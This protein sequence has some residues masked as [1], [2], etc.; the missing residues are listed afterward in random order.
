MQQYRLNY[1]LL[2]SLGVGFV[3][4]SAAVYVLHKYQLNRNAKALLDQ[5]VT[6]E[7]AGKHQDAADAYSNYLSIRPEDDAVRVKYANASGDVT[8]EDDVTP[9]DFGRGLMVM[10]ETVRNLPDEKALQKRLVDMYIKVQRYQDAI[11]HL[12]Y[13]LAKYPDEA[14][15]QVLRTESLVH[16]GGNAEALS[17]ALKLIGYD[18]KSD[19]FDV[20]KAIAPNNASSYST[21]ATLVRS[22]LHKPEVADRIM[23]Q[24]VKA[25]PDSAEAY[26]AR[27]RYRVAFDQAEKGQRDIEKAYKLKPDDADVLLTIADRAK[28]DKKFDQAAQYLTT[29]NKKYPD[30]PR[31]YQAL[32]GLSMQ[33]EKY[34]EALEI[35]NQGLKAVPGQ[36]G[37]GLLLFKADLQFLDNKIADVR[38]TMEAMR[39]SHFRTELID[40]QD[41]RILLAQGKWNDASKALLRLRPKLGDMGG[42]G[43]QMDIQL[44]ICYEK[45][46]QLDKAK[47]AY[48]LVL[49]SDATNARAL[50]GKQ[51][52][53]AMLH[54]PT[55]ANN[56]TQDLEKRVQ[57]ML[58]KPKAEQ[59][60]TEIDKQMDQLADTMKLEGV[61]RDLFWENL[62]L[63]REDYAAARKKLVDARN[64][65][66]KDIRV[67][68]AAIQLLQ[69]D[70]SAGPEKAMQL[71]D[72]VAAQYGDHSAERLLRADLLIAQKSKSMKD[73]ADKTSTDTDAQTAP[74]LD[75]LKSQLAKLADGVDSWGSDEKIELWNG[76]AARFISIGMRNE[77]TAYWS[78]VAD[79]RPD[80][81]PTRLTL[82]GIALEAG[83]DAG[84][85]DAQQKIFDLVG[86]KN[87]STWLYTEARRQMFLV[88]RGDLPKESLADIRQ[89]SDKAL[90]QRPDWF[91]LHLVKAEL[92]MLDGKDDKALEEFEK[93]EQLGRVSSAG[94]LQHVRLLINRGQY[95][96]AKKL[97]D[98]LPEATRE[99][100]LAQVYAEILQNTGAVEEAAKVGAKYRDAEPK[101]AARQ[102]WYGQLLARCSDT[103]S[104]SDSK[105]DA[106]L[107]ESGKAFQ[108]AVELD[109]DSAEA[110]MSLVTWQALRKDMDKAQLALKHAQ[111]AL[112]DDL[113]IGVMA[114]SDEML[115]R[116]FDA[117]SLYSTAYHLN[118]DNLRIAQQ[119]ATYYLGPGYPLPDKAAKATPLVNQILH[120]GADGKLPP[121]DPS[122]MWARRTAA[123]ML[124][125]TKE[126]QQLLKAENLLTSNL[127]KGALTADDQLKLAQILASRPEPLSRLKAISLLEKLAVN[128]RLSAD[129]ELTLGKLYFAVGDW[130]QCRRQM[131]QAVSRYPT[132]ADIRTAYLGMLL[133]RGDKRS[134][135]EASSQLA[136]LKETAPGDPRTLQLNVRLAGKT[137]KQQEARAEL[138]RMLPTIKDP[139]DLTDKQI[140]LLSFVAGLLIEL[141][142]LDNAEKILKLIATHDL[143]K[144]SELAG[145][146]GQYRDVGQSF[147]LLGKSY[148]PDKAD[149]TVRTAIAILRARRDEVGD[150][151]DS[152]VQAWL[153]RALLENPDSMPLLMLQAEFND[154]QKH[155]D[156]SATV[157]R[158]L[159]KRQD[160]TGITRAIVLNNLAYLVVLSDAGAQAD[161]DPKKLIDEASEILGPTTDVLDTRS[162]IYI[163]QKD[164]QKA[165]RD[166][167]LAITDA[168]SPSKY[169]HLA[170]AHLYAG[171][172]K[173]AIEAWDKAIELGDIKKDLNRLEHD[174]FEEIKSKIE[175]LKGQ[176]SKVTEADRPRQA[177]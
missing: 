147:D 140:P 41:A 142:D 155:Y 102:L 154:V 7:E 111:L 159:L 86:S 20:K 23:D 171:E 81:L 125:D 163:A 80:E 28:D 136:K 84:M 70:P 40:F 44:A 66:P 55:S 26:L 113:L 27:G 161:T 153:D 177:G 63:M 101:D 25:N 158:K 139:K 38:D 21:A 118:P 135:E 5:A 37:Q 33:N 123:Q 175:Q 62:Y 43:T 150:K 79:L 110:W 4:A 126:Y 45:L 97:V 67:Q 11:D 141:N 131:V 149:N 83:D 64:K 88:R 172:N 157:Y 24:A 103:S 95:E 174:R 162:V 72:K 1:R 166:S 60:W 92:E 42:L 151:Y 74:N 165:I 112:G 145:F 108:R 22:Q 134:Y 69:R 94:V 100:A 99:G 132:S 47:D 115:G 12:N 34:A 121:D 119:L 6:A 29:G 57:E 75:D 16:V 170:V 14:D 76:L 128:K 19:A 116:W 148:A 124:A 49:Q 36:K 35:V 58:A 144:S 54:P 9:E 51:R 146:L 106:F 82:F 160:L 173:A 96:G 2:I 50:A 127:Q 90:Q 78:K 15:L 31:F 104:L 109:P 39:K 61:S 13:M 114:K 164:Y 68:L 93:A 71:L 120:A 107:V 137:G 46:G 156:D 89:M 143:D 17:S 117:E 167:E 129:D 87:D 98:Q 30:D 59:I 130:T 169:F 8:E 138:L 85:R 18:E 32:A 53:D 56:S 176:G 133:N 105:K 10:E 73:Q 91:E 65:D 52:I 3:V 168:P 122:L 77:A 48:K 152:R